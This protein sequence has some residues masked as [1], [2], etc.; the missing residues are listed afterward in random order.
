MAIKNFV[1]AAE[2]GLSIVSR[3]APHPSSLYEGDVA[4]FGN[5]N[6]DFSFDPPNPIPMFLE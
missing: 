6:L 2:Q 4:Q 5:N 1:I 3:L